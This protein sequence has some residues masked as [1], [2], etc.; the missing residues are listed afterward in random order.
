MTITAWQHTALVIVDVQRGFDDNGH[1][2]RRN[3]LSCERNIAAL[4]AD[5]RAAGHP[6][7]L[8]RHDSSEPTS[9]LRPGRPGNAFKPVVDGAHDLL[10][11]KDVNSA[12]HGHPDLDAWLRAHDVTGLVIAGITTNHCCETTARVAANLHHRVLFALDATH[13]FDRRGPD[14]ATV[15]ADELTRITAVNLHEEFATI[16]STDQLLAMRNR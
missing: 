1:W 7:V 15:S 5:W 10:V 9:P 14:G 6:V 2:G 8:V 16:V 12:F 13:T 11:A 3:N 4:L